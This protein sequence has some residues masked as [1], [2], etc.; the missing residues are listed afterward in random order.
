MFIEKDDES[1]DERDPTPTV[2]GKR[3]ESLIPSLLTRLV[4]GHIRPCTCLS[5]LKYIF[6]FIEGI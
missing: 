2:K 6:T 4:L 5:T 3:F 1:R